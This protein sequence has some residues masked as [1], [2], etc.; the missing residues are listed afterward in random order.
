MARQ[1]VYRELNRKLSPIPAREVKVDWAR[2]DA[3]DSEGYW[4]EEPYEAEP[5]EQAFE[6]GAELARD[7]YFEEEEYWK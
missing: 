5:W 4:D 2:I 3:E 7:E 6:L 1:N